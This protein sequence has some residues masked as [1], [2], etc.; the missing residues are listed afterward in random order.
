MDWDDHALLGCGGRQGVGAAR[1]VE[2]I[3]EFGSI[4]SSIGTSLKSPAGEEVRRRFI[5]V[6]I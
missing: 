2:S 6:I 1:H 3:A 5:A 4:H